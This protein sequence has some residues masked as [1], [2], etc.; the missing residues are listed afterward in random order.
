MA[1]SDRLQRKRNEILDAA[2]AAFRRDGYES[3]SM[4]SIAEQAGA[5]KRTVYNHFGSKETLFRAVVDRMME[6]VRASKRV[7][8]D[9]E[10]S[11]REQL[12]SFAR[13]KVAPLK[14][15]GLDLV[16]VVLGVFVRD[17]EFACDAMKAQSEDNHLAI[18]LRDATAH[19]VVSVQDHEA[20]AELFWGM[21]SGTLF[22]PQVL[23]GVFEPDHEDRLIGEVVDTFLARFGVQTKEST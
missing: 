1:T 15:Q 10:R 19:E 8:F 17:P 18:W 14:T 23:F 6:T 5:S 13:A 4:D 9:P 20:V 16:H 7:K 3:T 11:A 22:W 21:V 12:Q 2:T